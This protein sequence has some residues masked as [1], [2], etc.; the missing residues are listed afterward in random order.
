VVSRNHATPDA[1]AYVLACFRR[2]AAPT[3]IG[4]EK[5]EI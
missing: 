2:R 3:I 1:P 5:E 4:L